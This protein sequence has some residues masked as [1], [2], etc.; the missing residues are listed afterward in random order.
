MRERGRKLVRQKRTSPADA[1]AIS[2]LTDLI[3]SPD[4]LAKILIENMKTIDD[5]NGAYNAAWGG[6]VSI[7]QPFT[8]E[9]RTEKPKP[10]KKLAQVVTK[11]KIDL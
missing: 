4:P 7:A 5:L 11:R 9:S 1:T 3:F 8:Y 10:E 2:K 6:G